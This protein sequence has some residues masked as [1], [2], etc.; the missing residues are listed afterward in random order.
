M[1]RERERERM[2]E[3]IFQIKL[4]FLPFVNFSKQNQNTH[5]PEFNFLV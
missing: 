5:L 1:Q 3:W 4:I 2:L